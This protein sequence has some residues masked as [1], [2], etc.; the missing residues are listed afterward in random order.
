[1]KNFIKEFKD[2]INQGNVLEFAVA[3][4]I[5]T[6]FTAI[7]NSVVSDLIMPLI[8]LITGGIDFSEMKV[9]IGTGPNAAAFTYGNFI[10]ALIQFILIALVIF[11]IVKVAN[12][13]RELAGKKEEESPA[14]TCPHCLEEVKEGATRCPHC[15]GVIEQTNDN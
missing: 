2:F 8:S 15:T 5:G 10:N 1:M 12:R 7:I 3:V 6:A 9:V 11:L 14:P 13:L 4:V